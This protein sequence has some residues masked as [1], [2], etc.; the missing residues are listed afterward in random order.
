VIVIGTGASAFQFIPEVAKVAGEVTI[1]QR[2]P[3]WIRPTEDYHRD[4]PGGKHWLLDHV[5]YYA[6]W[7]RFLMFWLT[8]EGM[9]AAVKR[10]P[11]WSN[12]GLSVSEAN[13]QLRQLLIDNVRQYLGDD[14]ELMEKSI[15]R[16]PPAGKRRRRQSPR[17]RRPGVRHRLPLNPHAVADGDQGQRRRLAA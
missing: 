13:E 5:P 3:P 10:D 11:A 12:G 14:P 9:L 1:F 7:Y 17:G 6:K 15:P 16:Y 8:A 2:T 4:V